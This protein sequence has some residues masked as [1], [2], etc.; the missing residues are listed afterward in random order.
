MNCI[1]Q[2]GCFDVLIETLWNVKIFPSPPLASDVTGINRNIMECKDHPLMELCEAG[3]VLIETLWN[4]KY[5][6]QRKHTRADGSINRNIM[7]CKDL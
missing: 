2:H 4:V 5:V 3:R 6:S 1:G 7:E